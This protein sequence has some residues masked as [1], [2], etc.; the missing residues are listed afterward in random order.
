MSIKD[1]IKEEIENAITASMIR[2]IVASCIDK[3]TIEESLT[4]AI[5]MKM[6]EW[7]QE[8]ILDWVDEIE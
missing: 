5:E 6:D 3:D 1:I 8:A 7:I 4:S 2:D